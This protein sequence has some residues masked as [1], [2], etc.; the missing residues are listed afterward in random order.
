MKNMWEFNE[1]PKSS[2]PDAGHKKDAAPAETMKDKRKGKAADD[3]ANDLDADNPELAGDD[4]IGHDDVSKAARAV[5]TQAAKRGGEERIGN[6][7]PEMP[8]DTTKVGKGGL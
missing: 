6:L 8:A 3:M 1:H 2:G 5:K 7:S 4:A